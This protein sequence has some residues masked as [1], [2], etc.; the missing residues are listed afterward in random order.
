MATNA[1]LEVRPRE[2]TG[3]GFNRKLR[4]SGRVPAVMYGHGDETRALT[5]DARELERLFSRIHVEN[6][7]I[8]LHIDGQR[9]SVR[10]LVREVQRH[11]FRDEVL[12]VDF[13]VLHAG[14]RI[15]VEIPIRLQGT[16]PGVRV[17]GILQQVL[18]SLEIRCLPDRIPEYLTVD[19]S[20][21]EIGDS[22]HVGDVPLPEGVES[23]VP[24]ERSLLSVIPPTVAPVDEE[25]EAVEPAPTEPELI[26]RDREEADEE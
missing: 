24:G 20:S 22:V 10:T 2:E 12:H 26:G 15:T 19:I 5:I 1:S 21:L 17:G 9:K 11:A 8:E 7:I 23:V 4:A 6:T 13:Y 25:A 18:D 3:K 16:A 14:E